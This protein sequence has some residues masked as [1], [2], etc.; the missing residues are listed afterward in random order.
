MTNMVTM[1]KTHLL[2]RSEQNVHDTDLYRQV[3][4]PQPIYIKYIVND[5]SYTWLY[6]H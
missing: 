6:Y 4:D 2:V 5:C 1:A 3:S